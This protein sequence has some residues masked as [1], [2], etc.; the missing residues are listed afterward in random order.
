MTLFLPG[1][2]LISN[3]ILKMN[4][5]D[6]LRQLEY[7][8][9]RLYQQK[10]EIQQQ[11]GY[12]DDPHLTSLIDKQEEKIDDLIDSVTKQIKRLEA[13]IFGA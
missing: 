9:N 4:R 5:L 2:L 12:L 7:Q 1:I 3:N 8:I 11:R 6:C 13:Q 10:M